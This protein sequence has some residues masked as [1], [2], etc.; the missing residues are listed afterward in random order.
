MNHN[1]NQTADKTASASEACLAIGL[2][3]V[4]L[5]VSSCHVLYE[6][7]YGFGA[8]RVLA[9]VRDGLSWNG[10]VARALG[11]Y[12]LAQ[13]ALHWAFGVAIFLLARATR[14]AWPKATFNG[15]ERV[16]LWFLASTGW[17]LVANATLFPHSA[18]GQMLAPKLRWDIV[19]LSPLWVASVI[20]GGLILTVVG[21]AAA[22]NPASRRYVAVA[23]VVALV[24]LATQAMSGKSTRRTARSAEAPPHVIL[25]GIDSLRSDVLQDPRT[26]KLVPAIAEF[27]ARSVVFTDT[28]TPLARTFPSWTSILTGRH[29]HTTGAFVN[30][31]PERF[32]QLGPTLP[33]ILRSNGYQTFYAIDES[34]FSN[35]D[36]RYGF[37]R[38][39]Y[40]PMGAADFILGEINDLPLS[41]LVINASLG[42]HLFPH[43]HANRA[44]ARTYDPDTFISAVDSAA[45][46]DRPTMMA[47][48]FTLVHW[49]YLWS[50][51]GDLGRKPES[52][53]QYEQALTRVSRQLEDLL[54]VLDKKGAL[55]NAIVILLSDHGEALGHPDHAVVAPDS[56]I[57][58]K[59]IH[60][61]MFGHGTSVLVPS[62]Y[63]TLLAVRRYGPGAQF[64]RHVGVPASLEDVAP[65]ILE[66]VGVSSDVSFDGRSLAQFTHVFEPTQESSFAGR[67]RFTESESAKAPIFAPGTL[68]DSS[69]IETASWYR[70]DS[71]T[72]R[73]YLSDDRVSELSREREYAALQGDRMLAALPT[74]GEPTFRYVWIA[75]RDAPAQM[76]EPA[77]VDAQSPE[78]RQIWTALHER[79]G[80]L[81]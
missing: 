64:V 1:Q 13:L 79:F 58:G 52:R 42:R 33:D 49:P 39:L 23:S 25:I 77:T 62:Q 78:L 56:Q 63:Q 66:M 69:I 47:I 14:V 43:A 53:K 35:I 67:I 34:R 55:D 41:N 4:L 32:V 36:E 15:R 70:V 81:D 3:I 11:G 54:S 19:G 57:G 7:I 76:I 26:A 48:H 38:A 73:I 75:G 22:R 31:I 17:V 10:I 20:V 16:G 18:L 9:A 68:I 61:A 72:G 51:S 37:D 46:F 71:K 6:F 80:P 40:P 8:S 24:A 50:D 28:T 74:F 12:V 45:N 5:L 29:P 44:V 30:L 60:V 27:A 2:A 65:T 59:P 21:V